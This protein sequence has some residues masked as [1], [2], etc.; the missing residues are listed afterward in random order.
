VEAQQLPEAWRCALALAEVKEAHT[1]ALQLA[2]AEVVGRARACWSKPDQA[3]SRLQHRSAA[4]RPAGS[5]R[6][7]AGKG[8]RK[9]KQQATHLCIHQ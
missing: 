2:G 3:E 4:G 7:R 9:H 1:T 8:Q 6:D 5:H